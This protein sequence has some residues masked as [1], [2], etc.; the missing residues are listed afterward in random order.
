MW[1]A[2]R[3]RFLEASREIV[4]EDGEREG[5]PGM[6]VTLIEERG[7]ELRKRKDAIIGD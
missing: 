4:G 6:L 5:L 7:A 2:F 1:R 3:E